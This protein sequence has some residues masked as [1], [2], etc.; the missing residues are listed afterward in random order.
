[1]AYLM[2]MNGSATAIPAFAGFQNSS[3]V[4]CTKAR[5]GPLHW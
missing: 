2:G 4:T 1:M 3:G 5:Q